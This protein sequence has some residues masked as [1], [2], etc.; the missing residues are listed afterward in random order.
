MNIYINLEVSARELDSKLLLA[1][2]AASR[3]HDVIISD[4]E[5]ISKGLKRKLL[6]PGIF[7]TKSLT[8]GKIKI[9]KHKEII[10]N[11]CKI[12]SI[13]EEGGLVDYGYERMITLR[14]SNKTIKQASAIFT[15]GPED[16]KTLKKFFPD[17]NKKIYM[18]GSPRVDLWRPDFLS[19][20][21]QKYKKSKKPF[22]LIPSNFG[23][24][25]DMRTFYE[26]IEIRKKRGYFDRDPELLKKLTKQESEQFK[27]ISCFLEAIEYL[28]KRNKNFDII[29]RPHPAEN[30]ELWKI[31]LEKTPNV[32]I[33]REDGVALWIKDAFAILHNG[34]TSALE[35]C[36][37]K[38][39]VISYIPFK[40]EF[41]RK[42]ANDLGQKVSS[43]SALSKKVDQIFHNS[44]LKNKR[45]NQPHSKIFRK[46][47]Y[48]DEKE[49]AAKKMIKVWETIGN[50]DLS[51]PNNWFLFK[52]NLKLMKLNG[53]LGRLIKNNFSIKR[54]FK[55]PP[56]QKAQI[57]FKLQEL[58]KILKIKKEFS[59]KLLSDR[60]LLIRLR[61]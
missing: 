45:S 37:L 10:F 15:W 57:F 2:V 50:K 30:I 17:S 48:V 9:K 13:D 22:L 41:S 60:T 12:T 27:L 25:T 31:L 59:I 54:N 23:A 1:V 38:T 6:S 21:K 8:P 18:T 33:I 11:G 32:K 5:S 40:A 56:F 55:F 36:F 43:L 7:H 47:I 46:K 3:G 26:R 42:L 52:C 39:P 49:T 53:A 58:I 51:K 34:C 35:A 14:Y 44:K 24:G 19:Y 61:K 16:F 28:A 4:Y 20:W 29:L